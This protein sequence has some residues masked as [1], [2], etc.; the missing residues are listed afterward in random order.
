LSIPSSPR[1]SSSPDS[2]FPLLRS[3]LIELVIAEESGLSVLLDAAL[4]VVV[5]FEVDEEG[6]Q[7]VEVELEEGCEPGWVVVVVKMVCGR[8]WGRV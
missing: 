2:T 3:S 1:D 4:E 5:E 6:E 8:W 7:G